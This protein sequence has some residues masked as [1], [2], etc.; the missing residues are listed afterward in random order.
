M[1]GLTESGFVG[2][3][4]AA[5]AVLLAV[6]LAEWLK[7]TNDRKKIIRAS[8]LALVMEVPY[9]VAGMTNLPEPMDTKMDSLWWRYR[10]SVMNS[11]ITVINTPPRFYPK[12][13][14]IRNQAMDLSAR[15]AAAEADFLINQYRLT[16]DENLEIS[17][18]TLFKTVFPSNPNLEDMVNSYRKTGPGRST[19]VPRSKKWYE[20]KVHLKVTFD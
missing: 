15:T 20:R 10:E 4:T 19:P 16:R 11:L 12:R 14:L 9:I 5:A 6:V 8:T 13:K 18:G 3:L 2:P 1:K 7:R 17:A